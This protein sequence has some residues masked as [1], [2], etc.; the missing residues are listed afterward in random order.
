MRKNCGMKD[1]TVSVILCDDAMQHGRRCLMRCIKQS[2]GIRRIKPSGNLV[3]VYLKKS[4]KLNHI[5]AVLPL[6]FMPCFLPF[7]RIVQFKDFLEG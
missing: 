5:V 2:I 7:S 3:R 4:R 6:T 1:F